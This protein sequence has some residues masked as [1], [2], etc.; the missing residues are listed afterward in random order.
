MKEKPKVSVICITCGHEDH[1]AQ[2][3]DSFLMQKTEFPFQ[4][5]VGA[6]KSPDRTAEIVMS[7]A[8]KYPD[9]IIPFIREESMGAQRNLIDLC[10]RAE[11]VYIA[12]CEG[13]DHWTDECKLQKQFDLM[14]SHPEY[15]M[16]FHDTV[17]M[18]DSL[19]EAIPN[20]D[21][22]I[23]EMKAGHYIKYCPAHS[24]SMFY[25][26]DNSREIPEWYY[27]HICWE[28]SLAMIQTGNGLIGYIPETM[29]VCGHSETD[30][31]LKC[32]EDRI[33]MAVDIERY[34]LSHYSLFANPEIRE[35]IVQEFNDYIRCLN[36]AGDYDL[37]GRAYK[38][39]AY[40]AGLAIKEDARNRSMINELKSVYSE[41]GFQMLTEDESIKENVSNTIDKRK[42]KKEERRKANIRKRLNGYI[43]DNRAIADKKLWVFSF[44]NQWFYSGNV[45]HL[46]EYILAYH[47][48]IS[49]VWITRSVSLIKLFESEGKPCAKIGSEECKHVLER[50]AVA[51]VNNYKI[52][53]F[54]IEGI[55]K[56][57]KIVRLGDGIRPEGKERFNSY[58]R[59]LRTVP[60]ITAEEI[61]SKYPENYDKDMLTEETRSYFT[62]DYPNTFLQLA[63]NDRMQ[64]F[65][66]E[67]MGIPEE[68][69]IKC[70]S[71]RCFA[72]R[73]KLKESNN[74]IAL[75]PGFRA[76]VS[77]QIEYA[78]D[79]LKNIDSINAFLEK[80]DCFLRIMIPN[81]YYSEVREKLR[82]AT[83]RF[84]RIEVSE[85][86]EDLSTEL[87][88]IDAMIT[89]WSSAMFDFALQNKPVVLL[90]PDKIE[91]YAA[92]SLLYKLDEVAPGAKADDW[93]EA[94]NMILE[95]MNDP[96]I[97][98]DKRRKTVET[99]YE[100][101]VNG[102]KDLERI[103]TEI[104][105][106]L[107][108]Q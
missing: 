75:C 20:H 49:A 79:L 7:Y 21:T 4:I 67:V 6:D 59:D 96:D 104:K 3:L 54:G 23:T 82:E 47:P 57:T 70:V 52:L 95:R 18:E 99:V 13:S 58:Q 39:Y 9:K 53:S 41:D 81:D 44:D 2:A 26:W 84:L 87:I 17:I 66:N 93:K 38:K 91:Q 69:I 63:E 102:E 11:T 5:L 103:V 100:T 98:S 15:N 64:R 24:S 78:D 72:V 22:E 48:E 27:T 40:P 55:N 16:C 65:Y 43:K 80:E 77:D 32:R 36:D 29:S 106:R 45:R 46:Y 94:L 42:T 25:R 30:Q 105:Q 73:D 92:D 19:P 88:N 51:F 74:V 56:N 97:D 34:F 50:A 86:A 62:E 60:F 10:R 35:R 71:P 89:D 61:I 90:N 37:L 28:H 68:A 107:G 14:E 101:A 1:I 33:E 31:L 12:T 85:P 108:I 83:D 8:E 76:S